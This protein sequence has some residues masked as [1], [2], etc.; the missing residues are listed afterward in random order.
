[1]SDLPLVTVYIPTHN[2]CRLL[3][4]AIDSIFLQT[5][6][7]I[8][9]IVVNDGSQDGTKDYLDE[10]ASQ[11][12]FNIK[13]FH[14]AIAKGACVAR[15]IAIRHAKGHYITGLDDD[16]EFLPCRIQELVNQF[17]EQ[18]SLVCTGF[19]W[20]YG[21]R[22]RKVDNKE[23]IIRLPDQLSYN[24]CSNQ[25][26]TLTERF[27]AI[28]GFD[29]ALVACQDYDMW[30]RLIERFGDAKRVAGA[31]YVVH[32]GDEVERITEPTNWLMGHRQFMAKHAGKMDGINI[33]NQEFKLITVKQEKFGLVRLLRSLK[34]G[35]VREKFRYFL[36]SNL[37]FLARLRVILLK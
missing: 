27:R 15:N 31:S 25:V 20:H 10:L 11:S 35:L 21:K 29:E 7:N 28:G 32:R 14:Q 34:G 23:K 8:E 13:V 22:Y 24:Y 19:K 6:P 4:R 30:T 2:R 26:L 12:K 37:S 33:S 9:L 17:D 36:S 5:Y 16:D 3:K 18:Y 1:M